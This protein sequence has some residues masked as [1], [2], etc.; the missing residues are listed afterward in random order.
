MQRCDDEKS[1]NCKKLFFYKKRLKFSGVL[2]VYCLSNFIGLSVVSEGSAKLPSTI[3]SP[4]KPLQS[5]NA[6]QDSVQYNQ[7]LS[8]IHY[9][10]HGKKYF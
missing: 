3:Q 6:H 7:D 2:P 5:Y 9:H 1:C 4:H 8:N 10:V